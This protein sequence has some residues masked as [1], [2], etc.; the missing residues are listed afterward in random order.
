ML[1]TDL[2]RFCLVGTLGFGVD[3]G[4][5]VALQATL[6]SAPWQARIPAFLA[7]SLVTFLLNQGWT[8]KVQNQNKLKAYGRYLATTLVGALLNYGIFLLTINLVNTPSWNALLGI[9]LG[10]VVGLGANYVFAKWFVF[11]KI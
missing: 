5:T 11:A 3:A 10:S 9:V 8:F 1:R 2:L 4:L 7:A 6:L